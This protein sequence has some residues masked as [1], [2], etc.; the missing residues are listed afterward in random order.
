MLEDH[1]TRPI[2]TEWNARLAAKPRAKRPFEKKK[3]RGKKKNF[4]FSSLS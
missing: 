4:P 1:E 2:A 3:K